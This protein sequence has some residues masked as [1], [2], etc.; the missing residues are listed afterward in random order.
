ML[1]PPE[2]S[3]LLESHTERTPANRLF[4][5]SLK[6][7]DE[8]P[9]E[10]PIESLVRDRAALKDATNRPFEAMHEETLWA[11]DEESELA[12]SEVPSDD[13]EDEGMPSPPEKSELFEDHTERN[14]VSRLFG[15]P[16]KQTD[17]KPPHA[18]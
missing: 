8:K 7:I 9:P 15:H 13:P 2:K 16:L 12:P 18:P 10:S 6:Q 3:E 11:P 5:N 1:S 17:E 14:T 4:G